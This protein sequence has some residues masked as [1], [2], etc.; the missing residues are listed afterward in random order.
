MIS[1]TA[2]QPA[3]AQLLFMRPQRG[4]WSHCRSDQNFTRSSQVRTEPRSPGVRIGIANDRNINP[5]E[6]IRW[7][8]FPGPQTPLGTSEGTVIQPHSRPVAT[9]PREGLSFFHSNALVEST[10][11]TATSACVN[12]QAGSRESKKCRETKKEHVNLNTMPPALWVRSRNLQVL[13]G[14]WFTD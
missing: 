8:I 10:I 12:K 3:I 5:N 14:C 1:T 7:A 4:I 11:S 9:S 6:H 13:S 2:E